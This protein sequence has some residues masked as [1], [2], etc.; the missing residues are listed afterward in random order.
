MS[1]C[2]GCHMSQ[3]ATNSL[4]VMSHP[5]RMVPRQWCELQDWREVGSPGRK[6][7]DDELHM[8]GE[9]KRRVQV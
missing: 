4:P 8:S 3:S 1:Q 9:W 2:T 7:S 6:W 5:Y